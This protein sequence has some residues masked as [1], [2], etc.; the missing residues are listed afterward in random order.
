M[1]TKMCVCVSRLKQSRPF[2]FHLKMPELLPFPFPPHTFQQKGLADSWQTNH[3]AGGKPKQ[4]K[5]EKQRKG[6]NFPI[7]CQ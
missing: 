6:D 5:H 4:A 1:H 7:M 3:L 2:Y